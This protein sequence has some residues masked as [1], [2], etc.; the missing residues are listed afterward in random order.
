MPNP[1]LALKALLDEK[2]ALYQQPGFIY[3]DPVQIPH[4]FIHQPDIE[5]MAF[6]AAMLAWGQRTTI[7]N[8]CSELIS[9]FGGQP[10]R[11]MLDHTTEDLKQ[12]VHF[13][14][15][16]FNG[17]DLLYFVHF[18]RHYYERNES[19]ETAFAQFL[20]PQDLTVEP[21]LTGFH[22]QFF[23]LPDAPPRTRKHVAT[24]ARHSACKRLNMF[25]R[26]M[27]RSAAGGVDFGLW[28][29]IRPAQLVCPLDVHVER[30]AR[31]L[32]LLTRKASDWEAALELTAHLRG[33]D[34][35]DPVKYDFALFGLG[36]EESGKLVVG[37]G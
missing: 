34:A 2:V 22:A 31:R 15:R 29:S 36:L 14:H 30:V 26:W 13:C 21:A 25:L 6:F 1:K 11:F 8:K 32:G 27:V 17:T 19:L 37:R 9:L 5:I 10:H 12:L 16:T 3:H 4:R 20:R 33:F 24:P 23:G 28:T 7:I 18:F 35:R